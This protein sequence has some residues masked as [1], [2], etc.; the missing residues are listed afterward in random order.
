MA[1][2]SAFVFVVAPHVGTYNSLHYMAPQ[3][4]DDLLKSVACDRN[5]QSLA[6]Y[7]VNSSERRR[8]RGSILGMKDLVNHFESDSII[9]FIS[10]I[11]AIKLRFIRINTLNCWGNDEAGI[12]GSLKC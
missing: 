10:P 6:K 5:F 3:K 4:A 2:R 7:S 9:K 12:K 11:K 1:S 8:R